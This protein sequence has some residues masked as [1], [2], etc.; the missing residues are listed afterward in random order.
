MASKLGQ[1]G[2]DP[3]ASGGTIDGA[4]RASIFL[5]LRNT[6]EAPRELAWRQFYDRYAPV[7]AGYAR[8]RGADRQLADEVVQDVICGF[9]AV[10]P[11]FVY[12][13][14]RGRFRGY[15]R[16]CA[17]HALSRLRAGRAP[18][19]ARVEELPI[20]DPRDGDVWETLWQQQVLRRAMAQARQH[21]ER[22]GKLQTFQA[23][24]QNVVL[25]RSGAE[26]ASIVGMSV[27]S[28]HAAKLR[29]TEK[30]REIR[31]TIED[32]EG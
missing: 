23:F 17:A 24:E 4:T 5:K 31:A 10:S 9:F 25:G 22:F 19:G 32:E 2:P 28:V 18:A 15:L 30:L 21:Y 16:T 14:S 11:R 1:V 27:A 7:I 8:A 20:V 3:P 12:D 13:P 26:T 6:D 29:V